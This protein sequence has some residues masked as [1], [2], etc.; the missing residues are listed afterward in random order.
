MQRSPTSA[1]AVREAADCFLLVCACCRWPASASRDEIVGRRA[2]QVAD[3]ERVLRIARRHRA[4]A[5]VH[6]A[7]TSAGVELPTGVARALAEGAKQTSRQGLAM[8]AEA[9]RLQGLLDAAHIPN[10]VLKGAPL[11]L[12][13]YGSLSLKH[14]RD[15]DLLVPPE[16]AAAAL[17][18]LEGEGYAIQQP[19]TP[20][21][22]AQRLAVV[23]FGKDI[24]LAHPLKRL[25][26]ELHWRATYN[27]YLPEGVDAKSPAQEVAVADRAV[28]TLAAEEQFAYLCVHGALHAWK[29]LKWLADLN[30]LLAAGSKEETARLFRR[31][32][33][34]GAGVC[35]G[36]A[37]LLCHRLLGL[38]L[39]DELRA[40]LNG[41][42]RLERLVAIALG[43]MAAPDPE[44]DTPDR[45]FAA[46]RMVLLPFRLGRGWRYL[47]AQVRVAS[48]GPGDVASCPLPPPLHF[49]YPLLRLPL[50]LH[51]Q[52]R[53]MMGAE[54]WNLHRP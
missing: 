41:S 20:L 16:H 45:P 18:L 1:D 11:A 14:G 49:L 28:R 5:L 43:A 23:R 30:A 44:G 19:S 3:W 38:E 37:L 47:A 54:R 42:R 29:R 40:E 15:I 52:A 21:S 32:Q 22:A 33:E 2:G 8:A 6:H 53:H 51:R 24:E 25:Q 4:L 17:E 31:A 50:W 12:L 10:V 7:L 26:V 9:I 13:A 36:Q 27:R 39:G 46:V 48:V 35:G 34:R